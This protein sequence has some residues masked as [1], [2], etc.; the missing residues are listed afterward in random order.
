[1]PAPAFVDALNEQIANEF[2]ASQQYVAVAVHYDA[3]TL[4]RLAAFFYRQAVEERG[5]A[6]KMVQYLMD[7]DAE[8]VIPAVAAPRNGFADIVE[9]IQLALEQEKQVTQQIERLAKVAR[10]AGDYQSEQFI[11]WFL[12]EQVEEVATM[13]DLLTTVTRAK[14][15]PLWVEEFLARESFGGED[16]EA[17]APPTAGGDR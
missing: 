4:P 5:H 17:G 3:D 16:D 11:Q 13:S 2:A 12:K 7:Q 6:L 15:N 1:M 10:E 14:E 9:P 8:V